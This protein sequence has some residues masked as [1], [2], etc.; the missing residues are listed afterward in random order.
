MDQDRSS[1]LKPALEIKRPKTK[2]LMWPLK[3]YFST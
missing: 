2:N 3:I 1:L